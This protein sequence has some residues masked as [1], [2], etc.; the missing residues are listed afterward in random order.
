MQ[1][2]V[3]EKLLALADRPGTI[4]EGE[5]ALHR[6]ETICKTNGWNLE[7]IRE[8]WK[9]RSTSRRANFTRSDEKPRSQ[10]TRDESYDPFGSRSQSTWDPFGFND[11][12]KTGHRPNYRQDPPKPPPPPPSLFDEIER[13]AKSCNYGYDGSSYSG[14]GN[15]LNSQ[16]FYHR[17]TNRQYP[18]FHIYVPNTE[19]RLDMDTMQYINSKAKSSWIWCHDDMAHA[20]AK[21]ITIAELFQSFGKMNHQETN[22]NARAEKADR[23]KPRHVEPTIRQRE[24]ET[25]LQRHCYTLEPPTRP[26]QYNRTWN[27]PD[28][29]SFITFDQI[30]DWNSYSK[31]GDRLQS[32]LKR[33]QKC[34]TAAELDIFL[35]KKSQEGTKLHTHP[36][37]D[38]ILRFLQKNGFTERGMA[39]KSSTRFF[40]NKGV[41]L[42]V[43]VGRSDTKGL[44]RIKKDEEIFW[45]IKP[46]TTPYNHFTAKYGNT[47]QEFITEIN[48]MI[49]TNQ[50][51]EFQN[52]P[53]MMA[54][55]VKEYRFKP[56]DET[57]VSDKFKAP[58]FK[59]YS[60]GNKTMLS[61]NTIF[62]Y[63]GYHLSSGAYILIARSDGSV[64]KGWMGLRDWKEVDGFDIAGLRKDFERLGFKPGQLHEEDIIECVR[65]M[66]S[67]CE[68]LGYKLKNQDFNT[69]VYERTEDM[70]IVQIGIKTAI[71]QVKYYD[72]DEFG[73]RNIDTGRSP[74][75]LYQALREHQDTLRYKASTVTYKI[76]S[77]AEENG[78]VH[79]T[80]G[81]YDGRDPC[82]R[83]MVMV[84][85]KDTSFVVVSKAT[86]DWDHFFHRK[87]IGSGITFEAFQEHLKEV[88]G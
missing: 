8:R 10:S 34:R 21:G 52:G 79:T 33:S 36:E 50:I 75:T 69:V 59:W 57:K 3:V 29:L 19:Q 44:G 28:R 20:I 42:Y 30:G 48:R 9:N 56:L 32:D 77:F 11:F 5:A 26:Y 51:D 24:L 78:F 2:D 25:V 62:Y 7:E 40:Q 31:I 82:H 70:S 17:W 54:K 1:Q 39:V 58:N 76:F 27:S 66:Q 72:L 37:F 15:G 85:G 16:T 61:G 14:V 13:L 80:N 46:G 47:Y 38:Q 49:A 53:E 41:G 4:A 83:D 35:T 86:G 68:M 71:H 60:V 87:I 81:E 55:L 73:Y 65:Q 88:Y 23:E 43:E 64:E 74:E 22:E 84:N 45:A 6:A 63:L 67:I 18:K 12:Y